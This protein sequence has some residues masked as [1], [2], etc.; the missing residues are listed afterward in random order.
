[1]HTALR[2]ETPYKQLSEEEIELA[3]KVLSESK[4]L[5]PP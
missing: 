1:M 3:R 2:A 4:C 5:K